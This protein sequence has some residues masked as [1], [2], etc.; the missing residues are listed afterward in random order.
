[1]PERHRGA[2]AVEGEA[3]VDAGQALYLYCFFRGP[4]VRVPERGIDGVGR[5]V[6][7]SHGEV[8]ALASPVS[9]EEYGE[10]AVERRAGEAQWLAPRVHRHE[11]LVRAVMD[12]HPVLPVRFGTLYRDAERVLQVLVRAHAELRAFLDFVAD[13]EEWGL[14]VYAS[15]GAGPEVPTIFSAQLHALDERL[16]AATPGEAHLIRKE[17]ERL[18]REEGLRWRERVSGEVYDEVAGGAVQAR[19]NP[20]LTRRATGR[21]EE[22]ILNAAFLVARFEVHGFRAKVEGLAARYAPQA[23]AFELTG[24]WAP[25]NFCPELAAGDAG[26]GP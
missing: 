16:A 7:I 17:R 10:E 6:V 2:E 1:M 18:A 13:K 24:P 12:A 4:P 3:R 15:E 23:L 22:M 20:R 19:R 25:Y 5:T 26:K 11:E 14:K 8:C 9:L 21:T